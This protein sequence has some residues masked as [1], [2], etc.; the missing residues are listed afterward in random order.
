MSYDLLEQY[1]VSLQIL[2]QY[3]GLLVVHIVVQC[4][5]H[6]QILLAT[7]LLCARAQPGLAVAN[8]I[9]LRQTHVT[10]RVDGI[11]KRNA[12]PSILNK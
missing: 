7:Q 1:V 12:L 10:L 9:G 2:G 8:F 11:C 3:H 5:M 6:Q 4:A